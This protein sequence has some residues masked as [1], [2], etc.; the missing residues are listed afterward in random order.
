M[1]IAS[2]NAASTRL[3]SRFITILAGAGAIAYAFLVF[4]PGQKAITRLGQQ[5][6]QQKQHVA[7]TNLLI[8]PI[9]QTQQELSATEAFITQWK[10]RAPKES[11]L[12]KTVGRFLSVAEQN[13]VEIVQLQPQ[14]EAVLNTLRTAVIQI[15]VAG[16][17]P[18]IFGM[19]RDMDEMSGV[20]WVDQLDLQAEAADNEQ[21]EGT[22]KLVIFA[23]RGEISG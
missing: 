4:V 7:Q 20:L 10:E 1:S 5:V 23:D 6:V 15:R 22:I 19:L 16:S 12:S 11:Q 13:K 14:E 3:R 18:E 2:P 21:L 9:S 8:Q 17:Y